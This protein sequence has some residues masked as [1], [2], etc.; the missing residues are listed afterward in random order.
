[1]CQT[2]ST[3]SA[4]PKYSDPLERKDLKDFRRQHSI[5]LNFREIS[6]NRI[7]LIAYSLGI[8]IIL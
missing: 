5:P 3:R 2:V 6:S 8:P 7:S 4:H 1:M